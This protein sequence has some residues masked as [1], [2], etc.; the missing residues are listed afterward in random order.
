ML[1]YCQLTG[2]TEIEWRSQII[3][4]IPALD[5]FWVKDFYDRQEAKRK[6]EERKNKAKQKPRRAR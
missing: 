4:F 6:E 2:R 3:R 5:R 1:S